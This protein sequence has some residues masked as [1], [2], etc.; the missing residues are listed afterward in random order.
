M[1]TPYDQAVSEALE[2]SKA[3]QAARR[4]LAQT[5]YNHSRDNSGVIIGS[6]PEWTWQESSLIDKALRSLEDS[7]DATYA[8]Y[9]AAESARVRWVEETEAAAEAA[10]TEQALKYLDSLHD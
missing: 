4:N 10:E 9:Q 3:L 1:N 7:L 6:T 5:A 8:A 2:A